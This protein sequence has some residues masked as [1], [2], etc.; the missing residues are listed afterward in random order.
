MSENAKPRI[1]VDI[2]AG[3]PEDKIEEKIAQYKA[4]G[5]YISHTIFPYPR[6]GAKIIFV[7]YREE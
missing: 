6:D 1:R 2:L 3:V 4:L 5:V 7:Q